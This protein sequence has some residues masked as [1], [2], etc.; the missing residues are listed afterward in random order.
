[1]KRIENTF[2]EHTGGLGDNYWQNKIF[3]TANYPFKS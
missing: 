1:M 3:L 2:S